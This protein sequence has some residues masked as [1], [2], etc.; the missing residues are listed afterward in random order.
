MSVEESSPP[1]VQRHSSNGKR[2]AKGGAHSSSGSMDATSP[3]HQQYLGIVFFLNQPNQLNQM[4]LNIV[5]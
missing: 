3:T 2:G 4:M 1:S 5:F